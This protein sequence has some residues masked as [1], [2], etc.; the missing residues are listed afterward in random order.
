[1]NFDMFKTL[2]EMF[3]ITW[4]KNSLIYSWTNTPTHRR[5]EII[6]MLVQIDQLVVKID[7]KLLG[8][9]LKKV[10]RKTVKRKTNAKS[11]SRKSKN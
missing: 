2:L 11:I 4:N 7:S 5:E 8:P 1:M 9:T 10:K 6:Y 3:G